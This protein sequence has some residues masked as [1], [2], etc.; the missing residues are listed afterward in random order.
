MRQPPSPA[1]G[2]V[3]ED[4][5]GRL[6]AHGMV[7]PTLFLLQV[8]L[9]AK[10]RLDNHKQF[11]SL[12]NLLSLRNRSQ[13][14]PSI[15]EEEHEHDYICEDLG[16]ESKQH[17]LDRFAEMMSRE[18]GGK[19]V[20]CVALRES[21][22]QFLDG[23]VGISLMVARNVDFDSVDERFRRKLEQ[24][25][26][27]IA[28]ESVCE[29]SNIKLELWEELLWY[30]QPRLDCYADSLRNNLKTFKAAGSLHNIPRL[31]QNDEFEHRTF[32]DDPSIGPYS[33]DTHIDYMR[34]A[35]NHIFALDGIL[36]TGDKVT[37]RRLLAEH[38]HSIRNMKSLRIFIDSCPR[39]SVGNGLLSDI[40]F[41]ARLRSCYDTLLEA[42]LNTPEFAHLS[43]IFVKNHPPRI[44]PATLPSLAD[45]MKYLDQ[46]LNPSS[47]KRFISAKASV[48]GA[49]RNFKELQDNTSRKPLHTHAEL[50]LVLYITKAADIGTMKREVYPYI[51]CSKLSCFLCTAFLESFD[52]DGVTFRTRGSHGKIYP[53]WSIP[54][55][56]GLRDEMVTALDS[57]FNKIRN[58]LV[59][60]MMKPIAIT[61]R[62]TESTAGVADYD[63]QS[64]YH[65]TLAAQREFD[66]VSANN[67]VWTFDPGEQL[68]SHDLPRPLARSNSDSWR[69]LECELRRAGNARN[70]MG[71]GCAV[72]AARTSRPL[73]TADYLVRACWTDDLDDLDEDTMEDFGFT[74]LFGVYYDLVRYMGVR[75]RELHKWRKEGTLT[76]NIIAKYEVIPKSSRGEYYP[77]FQH[78]L[79]VFNSRGGPSDFLAVARPYLDP[80]DREKEPHQLVPE[81]KRKSFM[82]YAILLDGRY[83]NPSIESDAI[84]KDLY[85]D[86]GFVTGCGSE[87]ERF[88][89]LVY[90]TL[91]SECSF[92][93]FWTA[94]QSHSLVALMDANGLGPVRKEV[95]H[96]EAFMGMKPEDRCPTVWY[97]RC[98]VHSPDADPPSSVTE[99]YGFLNCQTIEQKISLKGVY[100][101]LLESLR[102]VPMELHLAC[103]KG[104]LYDF[105]LRHKPNLERR[106]KGLMITVAH[107]KRML[108]LRVFFGLVVPSLPFRFDLCTPWAEVQAASE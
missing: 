95:Q 36:R 8:L 67:L 97:L 24:L 20:C 1:S 38:T 44:C 101:E 65:E 42:A 100:K 14:Y 25:L 102:V 27:A 73:D 66:A 35:Q 3:P 28:A 64:E 6:V 84:C 40:L 54:D 4:E 86:F 33:E 11:T 62:V 104:T 22:S 108:S 77:W 13:L 15:G 41:L 48:I 78:N 103:T 9:M 31:P 70:V 17:F 34:L 99:E 80:A 49:E 88:L 98:F 61:T 90:R 105:A 71:H 19:Y 94:F 93:Q 30:N 32:C 16:D 107:Y 96:F 53:L 106:F 45:A 23:D 10:F 2:G 29:E 21:G 18:K 37:R 75:S 92:T 59:R 43:I 52:Y 5:V 60:E 68:E 87:A 51:G 81:A 26:A 56:D 12:V 7:P 57:T 72:N 91:I 50:Q 55:M 39:V 83:P 76:E 74:K 82:L 85:I 79:H 46:A 63:P 69:L 58:A 47:V 89:P